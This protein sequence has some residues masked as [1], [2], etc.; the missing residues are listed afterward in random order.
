MSRTIERIT[1]WL[2]HLPYSEGVYRMS[3]DR[4]TTGMDA[5]VVRLVADDGT[6]G[7]GESGTTGVTYDTAYPGG[8]RAGM[9]LLGPAVIGCD[10]R[11]P[12][13]VARSM[14]RVLTGHP[15]A[16]PAS[17]WRAGTSL[18]GSQ[19]SHCGSCSAATAQSRRRCIGPF[20]EVLRRKRQRKPLERLAQGYSRLQV[21]VG[22]DPLVDAAR[23]L[24]VREAV[25]ANVP[26]YA[27]A[28][29]GFLLGAARSFVRALGSG[30]AGIHLEQPCATLDECVA[31]RSSWAGPMV[32]DETM[33]SLAASA[34]R[35]SVRHRRRRH[36]QAHSRRGHHTG[37]VD[38]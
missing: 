17:T 19:A 25:G 28:N 26:I 23:V 34:Q 8:Q 18:L 32:L 4:V 15:Y 10:P 12:A 37:E 13:A 7:I 24:A 31:L 35:T 11:S 22:D 16:R 36:G 6:V 3:G 33:V 9:E 30:G 14:H 27:D 20:R 38:A 29:C 5:L 2:V 21:K 1:A